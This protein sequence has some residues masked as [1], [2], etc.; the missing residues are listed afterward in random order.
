MVGIR[1]QKDKIVGRKGG[2]E[3]RWVRCS[4]RIETQRSGIR[5]QL[6]G[7]RNKMGEIRNQIRGLEPEGWN[8]ES[9]EEWDQE[10][11]G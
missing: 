5:N 11:D 9:A 4:D 3:T 2:S 8:Q 6:G 10:S 7:T 1:N